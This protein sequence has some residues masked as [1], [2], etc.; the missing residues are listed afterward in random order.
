MPAAGL[1]VR[2]LLLSLVLSAAPARAISVPI[3]GWR[4][5]DAGQTNWTDGE[6]ACMLREERLAQGYPGF[7]DRDSARAFAIRLQRAL[8]A[9]KLQAVVAQPVE[10]G[11]RWTVLASYLFTQGGVRYRAIQLYLSDDGRLRTVTGSNA[12]GEASVCVGEMHD[13]LRFLAN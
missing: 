11:D 7:T 10:R 4:A 5:L 12:D 8:M 9:Q 3:S 2:L 6:A 1:P 13:F